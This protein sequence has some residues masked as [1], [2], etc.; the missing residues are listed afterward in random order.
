MPGTHLTSPKHLGN[1]III[2]NV[3]GL[4]LATAKGSAKE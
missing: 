2:Y 4:E 3:M 1:V